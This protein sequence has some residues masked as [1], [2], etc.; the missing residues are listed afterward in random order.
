M[1]N[2]LIPADFSNVPST[3]FADLT[4][5]SDDF[6]Y[7]LQLYGGKSNAVQ[8]GKIGPNHYGIPSEDDIIDLGSEVDVAVLVWR[9]KALSTQD[10]PILESFDPETDLFKDI[11][12]R[13]FQT[14]SGCMYGPEFLLYVPSVEKFLTF[15]MSSKTA[16]REARKMEPLLRCAATLKSRIIKTAQYIWTGPVVLP[17]STPLDLPEPGILKN[18]IEKFLNPPVV[19]LAEEDSRER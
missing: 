14:N 9:A 3:S 4:S 13:S 15:F 17:C 5:A 12:N 19:E 18:K 6:F 2:E 16:R 8:E 11:K 10:E 1:P 7:R